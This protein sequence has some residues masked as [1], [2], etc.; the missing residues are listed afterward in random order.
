M[1][2]VNSLHMKDKIVLPGDAHSLVRLALIGMVGV[3]GCGT[4]SDAVYQ[5]Q[6]NVTFQGKPVP[7]GVVTFEPDAKSGNK[8]TGTSAEIV[9]GRYATEP[10]QG[11]VGG[12]YK[13][14]VSGYD[15]IPYQAGPQMNP[16]GKP[17]FDDREIQ[18]DL[19]RSDTEYDI[20]LP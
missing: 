7:K 3:F 9:D 11:I 6:G 19:P 10:S 14:T 20:V 18:A 13:M 17:L 12:P 4:G 15:G 5:I 1:R 16:M 8:G 2:V